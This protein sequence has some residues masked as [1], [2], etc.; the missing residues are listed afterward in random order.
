MEKLPG[1]KH[2]HCYFGLARK[3]EW[4]GILIEAV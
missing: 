1:E 2:R 3:G 4:W